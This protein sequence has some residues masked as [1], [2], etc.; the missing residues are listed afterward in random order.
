MKIEGAY[1]TVNLAELKELKLWASYIPEKYNEKADLNFINEQKNKDN[2]ILKSINKLE[3]FLSQ[4]ISDEDKEEDKVNL[5]ALE[6]IDYN[7]LASLIKSLPKLDIGAYW[8]K[9]SE[10]EYK[11][12]MNFV[13]KCTLENSDEIKKEI[14]LIPNYFLKCYAYYL[15]LYHPES[16]Y[17]F[18]ITTVSKHVSSV[19]NKL[20][21]KMDEIR[22]QEIHAWETARNR[23]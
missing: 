13:K 3:V 23:Y 12:C 9:F 20:V 7:Y 2:E 17:E 5:G 11:Y 18:S 14:L 16:N 15:L 10:E 6:A 22:N 8:Y 4:V 21:R 1:S 19:T